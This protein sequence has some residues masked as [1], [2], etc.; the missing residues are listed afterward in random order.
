LLWQPQAAL[1]VVRVAMVA[2]CLCMARQLEDV[3]GWVGIKWGGDR[4]GME[5]LASVPAPFFRHGDRCLWRT[6][7][8]VSECNG[9][10]PRWFRGRSA[11]VCCVCVCVCL[12]VCP[13]G[14]GRRWRLLALMV[15]PL[16]EG[17]RED[18]HEGGEPLG[19]R[20][21]RAAGEAPSASLL[22]ACLAQ[23]VGVEVTF[24]FGAGDGIPRRSC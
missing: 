13:A 17:R 9:G 23:A 12:C 5:W 15:A 20:R 8:E 4:V 24:P 7:R 6:S 22:H 1:M 10:R 19:D 11:S 14:L 3:M 2:A 21:G 16:N 18:P